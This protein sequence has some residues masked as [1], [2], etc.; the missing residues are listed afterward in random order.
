MKGF[1]H[2]QCSTVCVLTPVC[3]WMSNSYTTDNQ[4]LSWLVR[5]MMEHKKWWTS[6]LK[7]H[8]LE[9]A[10]DFC[11]EVI[12]NFKLHHLFCTVHKYTH[13]WC[14]HLTVESVEKSPV[15]LSYF[16]TVWASSV[17]CEPCMADSY[18]QTYTVGSL[19]PPGPSGWNL[20]IYVHVIL[21]PG[22]NH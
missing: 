8:S 16:C 18:M 17:Q 19:P 13:K 6:G 10:F 5:H 1:E 22:G 3:L 9:V 11:L 2:P 20:V 14:I 21:H 7:C 12:W 4:S 15:Q